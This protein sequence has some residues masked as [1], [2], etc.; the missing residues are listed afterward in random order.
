MLQ[1]NNKQ[2]IIPALYY[3][4]RKC[5]V[6]NAETLIHLRL[7]QLSVYGWSLNK[8]LQNCEVHLDD[9]VVVVVQL[10]VLKYLLLLLY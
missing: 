1:L 6:L 9:D 2:R 8:P 3:P 7:S 10:T 5:K 4:L